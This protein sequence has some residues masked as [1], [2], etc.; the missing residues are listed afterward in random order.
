MVGKDCHP[1]FV[2]IVALGP[3][4]SGSLADFFLHHAADFDEVNCWG[5]SA[6]DQ[7]WSTAG[8]LPVA[9]A[10]LK[11]DRRLMVL[12]IGTLIT[13]LTERFAQQRKNN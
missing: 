8:A 6:L 12:L 10:L 5:N 2:V 3:L 9:G 7:P 4:A 11:S 1:L 13:E